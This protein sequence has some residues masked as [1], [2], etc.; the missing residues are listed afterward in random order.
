MVSS[1]T[2]N[3]PCR[4]MSKVGAENHA[5]DLQNGSCIGR[6]CASC[7]DEKK[8]PSHWRVWIQSTG[9]AAHFETAITDVTRRLD[10]D[11]NLVNACG[12]FQRVIE[13][14]EW[15]GRKGNPVQIRNCP[16]AVSRNDSR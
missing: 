5:D 6:H 15:S 11:C 1:A 12:N 13:W 14:P 3:R 10:G 8:T 2:R 9:S 7:H 4:Y 16:A